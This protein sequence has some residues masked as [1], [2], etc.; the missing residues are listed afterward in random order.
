MESCLCFSGDLLLMACLFFTTDY[1]D[2]PD[3]TDAFY[4]CP[5]VA[6]VVSFFVS[7]RDTRRH[8]TRRSTGCRGARSAG[9]PVRFSLAR[10]SS[11]VSV[12]GVR[13]LINFKN[14]CHLTFGSP[15][16]SEISR[17]QRLC[18]LGVSAFVW[19]AG[20]RTVTDSRV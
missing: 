19:S 2:Y 1:P 16:Q 6:S 12:L 4:P 3:H 14:P 5:S 17:E 7:W 18:T 13:R 11:S 10:P 9:V 15:G 20:L 8:L